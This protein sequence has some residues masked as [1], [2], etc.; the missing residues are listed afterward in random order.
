MW[1]IGYCVEDT[2]GTYTVDHL[3]RVEVNDDIY[4]KHKSKEDIQNVE[5][6]QILP[7]NVDGAWDPSQNIRNMTFRL[8]NADDMSKIFNIMKNKLFQD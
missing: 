8:H 6:D 2:S 3:E 7:C 1:E 4:W 5:S